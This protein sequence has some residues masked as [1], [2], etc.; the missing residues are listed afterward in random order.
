M[1]NFTEFKVSFLGLVSLILTVG[2]MGCQPPKKDRPGTSPAKFSAVSES[3]VNCETKLRQQMKNKAL[4]LKEIPQIA[5]EIRTANTKVESTHPT[6]YG[7]TK[8]QDRV[9]EITIDFSNQNNF[10]FEY[11][12]ERAGSD[13]TDLFEVSIK[14]SQLELASK[15][16][17]IE[18]QFR[19]NKTCE[20]RLTETHLKQIAKQ[21]ASDYSTIKK[22]F[23]IDGDAQPEVN[24][25]SLPKSGILLDFIKIDKIEDIINFQGELYVYGDSLGILQVKLNEIEPISV[26]EFGLEIKFDQ[27]LA[28]VVTMNN[29]LLSQ[30]SLFSDSKNQINLS[31]NDEQANTWT[32]SMNIWE[33]VTLGEVDL[34]SRIDFKLPG[35]YLESNNSLIIKSKKPL[36]Y[37]NLGAYWNVTILEKN[38]DEV[39]YKLTEA[40][41][42]VALDTTTEKD[43]VS[44][45]TIQTSLPEI[46]KIAQEIKSQTEVRRAQIQ[47]ILDYLKNN[48]T[49]DY[50]MLSNNV[51]RP[52]TTKEA[53]EKKKGV[54]QHYAVIFTAVARALNIP[55]R[56]IAGYYL[57]DSAGGHAWNEVEI[58]P[59]RWQVIE[60]QNSSSLTNLN[61]RNYLPVV[62]ADILED[63]SSQHNNMTL[64]YINTKLA[65]LP[66]Q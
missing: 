6:E 35:D 18:Q 30:V 42:H 15:L 9:T 37:Q 21:S 58:A 34:S 41:N 49:Y 39:I 61:T 29:E 40:S 63:K 11:S 31:V 17:V 12:L 3:E 13:S 44:N 55:A 16:D 28:L 36:D 22:S 5:N 25:F 23:Y 57:S 19:A 20:L 62:R 14:A 48:Y 8:S 24:N 1:L 56:I 45:E 59:G 26:R 64:K 47:L 60:P 54:C 66:V 4:R 50:D 7:L 53:L 43:L 46:Q 10:T 51:V 52:L 27:A 38:N 65:I 32:V 2:L 33:S